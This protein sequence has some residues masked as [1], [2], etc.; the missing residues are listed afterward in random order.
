MLDLISV[1][2]GLRKKKELAYDALRIDSKTPI[3]SF[4]IYIRQQANPNKYP[5]PPNPLDLEV[6][7]VDRFRLGNIA[8]MDQIPLEFE[9]LSGFTYNTVGTKSVWGRSQG[10]GLDKHQATVQLTIHA[11]RVPR[12]KPLLDF[13]SKGTKITA[14]EKKL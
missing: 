10:S 4:H 14:N 2:L 8:N 7:M 5:A 13:R 1:D 11:D 12:T 9:F 3:Q 6:P